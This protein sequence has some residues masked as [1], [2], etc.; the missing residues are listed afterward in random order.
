MSVVKVLIQKNMGVIYLSLSSMIPTGIMETASSQSKKWA[1]LTKGV[2]IR[3]VIEA[4]HHSDLLFCWSQSWWQSKREDN[5]AQHSSSEVGKARKDKVTNP[6]WETLTLVPTEHRMRSLKVEGHVLYGL[7]PCGLNALRALRVS[8]TRL[9]VKWQ[10]TVWHK[11][12]P[13][14]GERSTAYPGFSLVC[15]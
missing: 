3:E 10:S 5:V 7:F 12:A 14:M 11:M 6:Q 13:G 4:K 2:L 8:D 9:W 15:S 1:E